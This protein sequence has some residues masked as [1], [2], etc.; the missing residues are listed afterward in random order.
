MSVYKLRDVIQFSVGK[1]ASR[2][3]DKDADL[4]TQEDFDNDLRRRNNQDT[5]KCIINLMKSKA[6]MMTE[7]TSEKFVTSNFIECVI[8]EDKL[9]PWYFVYKF[10]EDKKFCQQFAAAEQGYGAGASLKRLNVKL[11]QEME[12]VIPNMKEQVVIGN[13][14]K[15]ALEKDRLMEEQMRQV[16]TYTMEIIRLIDSE[17]R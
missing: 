8:D 1:N 7:M 6:T 3:K 2:I 13:M 9:Y 15:L 14:Y 4:Y 5:T 16:H 17:D 11:L 12:I 10:N